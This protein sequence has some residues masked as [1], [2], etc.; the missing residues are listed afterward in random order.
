MEDS[1]MNDV[2]GFIEKALDE[3]RRM[4]AAGATMFDELI[5]QGEDL[6][7]AQPSDRMFYRQ[8][9]EVVLLSDEPISDCLTLQEMADIYEGEGE[10]TITTILDHKH[11]RQIDARE[12]AR[13]VYEADDDLERYGLDEHGNE[14]PED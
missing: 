1:T 11:G 10:Q 13:E 5:E 8:V 4:R 3:F 6:E 9:Y 14:L 2:K 12:F 7:V